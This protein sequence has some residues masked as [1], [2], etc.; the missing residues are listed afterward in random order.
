[1]RIAITGGTGFIGGH[2]ATRL[3]AEGHEVILLARGTR[4]KQTRPG[5][6]F[7][8]SDLSNEIEA[9]C[10]PEAC[11]PI[12]GLAQAF[13]GCEAVLHCAGINR[14]IGSQ[15]YQKVHVEATGNVVNAAQ[16]AGV[17][18]IMLMSFLRARPNCGSPYHESKWAAE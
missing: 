4:E 2:L 11:V 17:S 16:T 15:T 14:E 10:T 9:T 13:T 5:M 8:A 6:K 18:K 3:A 1:M 7:V 12:T